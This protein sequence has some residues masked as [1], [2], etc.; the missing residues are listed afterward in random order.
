MGGNVTRRALVIVEAISG[1]GDLFDLQ[2]FLCHLSSGLHNTARLAG[3]TCLSLSRQIFLQFSYHN[4]GSSS[5]WLHYA[6]CPGSP[7][8]SSTP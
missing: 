2:L 6:Q 1:G 7:G 3:P 4:C 8:L 5:E